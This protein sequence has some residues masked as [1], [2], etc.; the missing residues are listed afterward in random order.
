MPAKNTVPNE[1]IAMMPEAEARAALLEITELLFLDSCDERW[2]PKKEWNVEDLDNIAAVL[3][4][5]KVAHTRI[6][7]DRR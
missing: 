2:D 5:Y 4:G 6:L 3:R 1:K 7:K